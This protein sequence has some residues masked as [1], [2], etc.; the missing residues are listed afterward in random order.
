[1]ANNMDISNPLYKVEG[2]LGSG[3]GGIVYKAWH[4]NLQKSVVIKLIKCGTK[5]DIEK[6]RIEVEALK[7][8][9]SAYLPQVYDFFIEDERAYTVMEYIQGVS[10]DKLLSRN[11]K[12][13]QEQIVKWY[14]QLA[15]ALEIIHNQNIAH[16]DIKPANIMLLP[17]DDVCLIDFNAA[18]VGDSDVRLI[19][20]SLGYASPEQ[21]EIYEAFKNKAHAPIKLNASST[22]N[23]SLSTNENNFSFEKTEVVNETDSTE[24]VDN[25][26]NYQAA[27]KTEILRPRLFENIDWMLSDIYSLGATM[28]H[29]LT[30]VRPAE[31]APETPLLSTVGQYDEGL[32]YIIEGSMALDPNQRI[33]SAESLSNAIKNIYKYDSRWKVLQIKQ[34]A[35][36][37]ILP[38]AL[39]A[40][41]LTSVVG[42]N[43]MGQEKE[44]RFYSVVHEI[45][46]GDN[47]DEAYKQAFELYEDRVEPYYAMAQR[48]WNNGD[49]N[50][51]REYIEKNLGNLTKFQMDENSAEALGGIY[52]IFG[53]CFYYDSP[54]ND[55]QNAKL[56]YALALNYDP[57]NPVYHRDY[58]I[59]LARLGD[60]AGARE[61]LKKA[62][63]LKLDAVSLNLLN[64]EIDYASKKYSSAIKYFGEVISGSDDE[65]LRYRAYHSSDEIFKIQGKLSESV[66]LLSDSLTKIPLNRVPEMQERLADSC[67]KIGDN[68][69]AIE[70]FEKLIITNPTFTM[71]QNLV[72]LYQNENE[73][74]KATELLKK[75]MEQYPND[76]RVPMRQAFLETDVQAHIDIEKRD[77]TKVVE[78]YNLAKQLYAKNVKPGESDPE[79]QQLE[80]IIQQLKDNKWIE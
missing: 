8:V 75:M 5:E 3:G 15:S 77:Y 24:I 59:T 10:F 48:L 33:P 30:N 50:A 11:Y 60:V 35:A 26:T 19:S 47:P 65:Y 31:R 45:E 61:E 20:R 39:S 6:L 73:F 34:I 25:N 14:A 56:N 28:Y 27:D 51:C 66:S 41:L 1:M 4:N 2:E 52:Y 7:N 74:T 12:F 46:K 22:V 44:E 53:D 23:P 54:D 21:Y 32:T 63:L 58:A 17:N 29:L 62:E 70:I 55:Y 9:K 49:L 42:Y 69:K 71:Q 37:V 13:P 43:K 67:Y 40:C 68:N 80:I 38:L 72:I 64:G 57:K 78:Y 79:M 18:L 36:A 16:R 76:Y